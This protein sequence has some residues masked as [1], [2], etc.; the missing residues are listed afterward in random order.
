MIRIQKM[1]LALFLTGIVF[2]GIP[3]KTTAADQQKL[4]LRID[5]AQAG[6]TITLPPGTYEGP[7]V[8]TKP[9][10]LEA[11]QDNTVVLTN[12]SDQPA[13]HIDTDNVAVVGL[14]IRDDAIKQAPSVLVTGDRVLLEQLDIRT[15][16]YGIVMQ[17]ANEGQVL[18][19]T[20]AWSL[21][22]EGEA[23]KMS[24]K[25]NGIDL[26]NAHRNRLTGNIIKRVHDG[27]YLENSDENMVI[28]NH[29][30]LSRY[31]VHCMYTKG[32]II[33]ENSSHMNITGA[34]V[35]ATQDVEVVNNT[36]TKQNE[37]VNS[38]GILLYDAHN[39]LIRENLVE[40]NRVGLFV[41]ESANNRIESN[42][43]I[44]NFIGIQLL[45][46][47]LNAINGNL[48]SGNVADA[49]AQ[50]STNNDITGNFWDS[51]RGID[52]DGDGKSDI[53]YGIN[54]FFQGLI[55]KRPAFQLFFQSPG[56]MFL[57]SLYQSKQS[58][59]TTD[60]SPL[61]VPPVSTRLDDKGSSGV[62]TG[63][64]GM[65]L[66]SSTISLLLAARRRKI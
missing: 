5:R 55:K 6:E 65:L 45:G 38:Q 54:P 28:G 12:N 40:G 66:S 13:L 11:E 23:V 15:G 49:Q 17:D 58:L 29:I 37:N 48:F 36:F 46:S 32:T 47:E 42:E 52:T 1:V 10:R 4:Q 62:Q 61:M 20:I 41:E 8:I 33:R 39:T 2:S 53:S 34:M 64:I 14:H 22:E 63:L 24:N 26:Y 59:W 25:G 7:L 9:L 27:I 57:E 50:N 16:S 21:L 31:G 35:M 43:V 30:E 19:N 56:M 18:E 60:Y 51:F 3:S 44:D